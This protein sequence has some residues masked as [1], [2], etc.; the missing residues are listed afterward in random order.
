M[1][2][3]NRFWQPID[4]IVDLFTKTASEICPASSS[5]SWAEPRWS[6]Q[7]RTSSTNVDCF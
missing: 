2:D 7:R 6:S 5:Y 4:L 3:Q 1:N